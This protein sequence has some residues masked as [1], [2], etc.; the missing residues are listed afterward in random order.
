M[1]QLSRWSPRTESNALDFVDRF[2]QRALG[3]SPYFE[4]E[5]TLGSRWTPSTDIRETDD[6]Y[7]VSAELP[8]MTK[9]DVN[10]T[11]E[12]NVLTLSGERR[13]DDSTKKDDYHRIERRYGSFFRSFTLPNRVDTDKVK[14]TFT[15]GVLHLS[16]PKTEEVK[17]RRIAIN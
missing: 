9:D 3:S 1:M 16:V 17:P 12:N 13:F 7:E 14:A 2:F 15:D 8:G 4:D 6:T 11:L 10:V 5:S